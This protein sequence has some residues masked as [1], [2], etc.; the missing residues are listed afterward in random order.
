MWTLL[1]IIALLMIPVGFY[2]Y[3]Y[4]KRT[5]AFFT[6]NTKA[7]PVKIGMVI[8]TVILTVSCINIFSTI[9]LVVFH[10]VAVALCMEVINWSIKLIL[11]RNNTYKNNANRINLLWNKVYRCGLI[12]ILVTVII[13]FYGFWNMK[14][15]IETDYTIYTQKNIR[16]EGYRVALIADLHFGTVMDKQ[17][18]QSRCNEIQNTNPDIVILCGDIVDQSTTLEEMQDA[19]ELLGNIHSKFGA[20]YVYGNHDLSSYSSKPNFTEVQLKNA[21]NI[22]NIHLLVDEKYEINDDIV[23][24]GRDDASFTKDAKRESGQELLEKVD[25][26]KFV[27]VLDHQPLELKNNSKLGVDLQLSGHTHGGQIWP[28]GILSQMFGW[29]ELNYGYEKIGDF[30]VIVSSGI[31]GWGYPIR[32]GAHSEYDIINIEK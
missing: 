19:M 1:L 5:A 13:F 8:I 12:P 23:V 30:Q 21:L 2:L 27:L 9:A 28:T 17:S 3:T 31:S 10:I 29:E 22:N 18:L 6:V 4:L 16:E 14:N 7:K 26:N 20:Y 25:R 11:K 24:V 32:T 15:V